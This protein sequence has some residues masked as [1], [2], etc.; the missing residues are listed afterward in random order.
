MTTT[1]LPGLFPAGLMALDLLP[2]S[3]RL[4]CVA[5]CILATNPSIY[6]S[7]VFLEELRI[8]DRGHP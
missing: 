1:L 5:W 2:L 6:Q 3:T 7:V 4:P 8:L